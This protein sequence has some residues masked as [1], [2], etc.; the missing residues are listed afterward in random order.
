MTCSP[1]TGAICITKPGD[2]NMLRH[3]R[4]GDRLP[5]RENALHFMCSH[6]ILLL[7]REFGRYQML[8]SATRTT[9]CHALS[10]LLLPTGLCSSTVQ[11][12]VQLSPRKRDKSTGFPIPPSVSEL[13]SQPQSP[14]FTQDSCVHRGPLFHSHSQ[15]S[16]L[17]WQLS[18]SSKLGTSALAAHS[19]S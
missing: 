14:G 8:K 16:L 4:P 3:A 9:S 12:A 2:H 11:P 19:R 17:I 15:L 5:R 6:A 1:G 13:V 7:V 10:F 18:P